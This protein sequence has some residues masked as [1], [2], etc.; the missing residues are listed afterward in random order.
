LQKEVLSMSK[1]SQ[2][3]TRRAALLAFAL[4]LA[5]FAFVSRPAE[6]VPSG[7]KGFQGITTYYS[8]AAHTSIVG[9]YFS[10]CA[11]VCNGSGQIT[12]YYTFDHYIC[13]T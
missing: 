9:N 11:G 2:P 12:Q 1:L 13:T 4:L 5:S 6:A 8:N 3:L 7:C 10:S